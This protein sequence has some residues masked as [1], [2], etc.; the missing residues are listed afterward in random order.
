MRPLLAV[1]VPLTTHQL[2]QQNRKLLP[3]CTTQFWICCIFLQTND[4]SKCLFFPLSCFVNSQMSCELTLPCIWTRTSCSCLCSR[5][6][7]EGVCVPSPCTSRLLSVHQG[8]TL[9]A[10]EMLYMLIILF[11]PVPWRSWKMAWSWPSWVS[12]HSVWIIDTLHFS[13]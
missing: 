3:N 11:V 1:S 10:K 12:L 6:P 7:A 13:K 5:E 4:K 2:K 8:N 9:S